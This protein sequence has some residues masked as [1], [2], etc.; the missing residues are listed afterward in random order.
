MKM[1][2]ARHRVLK[3]YILEMAE[4]M[5]LSHYHIDVIQD[6]ETAVRGMSVLAS[7]QTL[8]DGF[9]MKIRVSR[10]FF[11]LSKE[12]QRQTICHELIHAPVDPFFQHVY[13]SRV[14]RERFPAQL[15]DLFEETG[16]SQMERL[17]DQIATGWSRLLPLPPKFP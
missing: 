8:I 9:G 11:N 3:K 13:G 5:A 16:R 10:V 7:N 15:Y 2:D 12:E 17:V 14:V 1:S 4:L 6:Y